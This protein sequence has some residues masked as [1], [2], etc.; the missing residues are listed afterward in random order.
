MKR[1]AENM[2]R[3]TGAKTPLIVPRVRFPSSAALRSRLGR[4]GAPLR[5]RKRVCSPWTNC[6]MSSLLPL[7]QNLERILHTK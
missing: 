2:E 1:R 6:A 3:E 7:F 4:S 5:E